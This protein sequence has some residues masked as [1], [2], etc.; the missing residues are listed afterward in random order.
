MEYMKAN[1]GLVGERDE[2]WNWTV[3]LGW[4]DVLMNLYSRKEKKVWIPNSGGQY[5]HKDFDI[6][7]L[8]NNP[9]FVMIVSGR[10]NRSPSACPEFHAFMHYPA[11]IVRKLAKKL[12]MKDVKNPMLSVHVGHWYLQHREPE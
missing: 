1:S 9:S 2:R 8:G 12:Y 7:A 11:V 4:I 3:W 5:G 10:E 6:V